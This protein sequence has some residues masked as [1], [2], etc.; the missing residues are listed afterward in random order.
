MFSDDMNLKLELLANLLYLYD[1]SWSLEHEGTW[2]V[3]GQTNNG[4]QQPEDL[5]KPAVMKKLKK[6][7]TLSELGHL[8]EKGP[9]LVDPRKFGRLVFVGVRPYRSD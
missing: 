1:N 2:I 4:T 3:V 9:N 7:L 8:L 5:K 6:W